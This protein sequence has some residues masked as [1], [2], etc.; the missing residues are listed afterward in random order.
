MTFAFVSKPPNTGHVCAGNTL[1]FKSLC[2]ITSD[3][4]D[5]YYSMQ[6]HDISQTICHHNGDSLTPHPNSTHN[7]T[8]IKSVHR[9]AF[10]LLSF[11]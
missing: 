8:F 9:Y 3:Y 5:Q 11:C 7:L 2:I 10:T 4:Y 6:T 1:K